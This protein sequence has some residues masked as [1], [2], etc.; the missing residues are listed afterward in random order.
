MK[1]FHYR[2]T[3]KQR[4]GLV[5]RLIVSSDRVGSIDTEMITTATIPQ[6]V[7]GNRRLQVTNKFYI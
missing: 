1:Q 5:K 2:I 7:T 4:R 6:H 3:Q